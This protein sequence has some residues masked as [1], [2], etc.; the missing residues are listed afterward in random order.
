MQA[1]ISAI[2]FLFFPPPSP[3]PDTIWMK[4][5]ESMTE[6]MLRLYTR[7]YLQPLYYFCL[8]KTG[9]AEEAELLAL[10][11]YRGEMSLGEQR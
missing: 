4:G 5:S 11:L 6:Q 1:E 3:Q 8:R 9:S 7:D 2:I 10:G